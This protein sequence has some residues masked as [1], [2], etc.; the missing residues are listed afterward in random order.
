MP[1][2]AGE[3]VRVGS[4]DGEGENVALGAGRVGA[5]VGAAGRQAARASSRHN[6]AAIHGQ[7]RRREGTLFIM[8][9]SNCT[10]YSPEKARQIGNQI[11]NL[12][13]L[14]AYT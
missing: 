11:R 5:A 1:R 2:P 4:G 3:G 10:H 14:N 13:V 6:A 7:A 12:N 9:G 8:N